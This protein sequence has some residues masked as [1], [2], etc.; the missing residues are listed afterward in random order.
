MRP[1]PQMLLI[2]FFAV[3]AAS[4]R[5][6]AQEWTRFRGPNGSGISSAT[7]V[8]TKWTQDDYNWK[9]KLPGV[10][11]S[12]PVL[13]G[14]RLF[15]TSGDEETGKR[16]VLC[17]D[18][19]SGDQIWQRDFQAEPNRKHSLN[20]FASP[21]PVVDDKRVY[22]SWGTPKEIV[23]LALNHD[24][25][26]SWRYDLG[27]FHSGHGFGVSPMIY[28]E[29]LIM[30]NDDS[31][32]SSW[33]A[34]DRSTGKIHWKQ[35]RETKLHYSTPCVFRRPNAAPELIFTNYEL[36]ICGVDP[37]TGEVNWNAKV[38][39]ESH[40]EAAIASPVVAGDL[41]IGTCGYL[42]HG[43]EV[44]AVRPDS[45][46][47]KPA[48]KIVWR[49]ARGAPLCPTPLVKDDMIFLFSDNGIATCADV[50]T[51]K[52]HWQK[53]IGGNFYSSP[54]CIGDYIYNASVDGEMIVLAAA[55]EYN[56][57]ARNDLGEPSHAT[58][59][60]VD[61]IMYARTFSHLFSI[62]GAKND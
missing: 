10:G 14:H 43:Y 27:S 58:P 4:D 21:T 30:P 52:L 23:I 51:G 59:A 39:D 24:G 61:G 15:I 9:V 18:A 37:A 26:E 11:H 45:E 33:I 13:W 12:S 29:S 22:V 8:P 53:R 17:F 31:T 38:F 56:L 49:I 34:L 25:E 3:V 6:S 57:V 19:R 36:G 60:V 7:T 5:V 28:G 40:V 62:G 55:K 44:I 46:A 32:D 2:T 41:V 16:I 42:G 1:V 35:K 54:I 50:A 20:S 48:D 47:T